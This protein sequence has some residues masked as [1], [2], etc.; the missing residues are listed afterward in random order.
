M[1]N[2]CVII[3]PT[4]KHHYSFIMLHPMCC[5]SSYFND[6]I[7]YFNNNFYNNRKNRNNRNNRNNTKVD[8]IKY[9]LPESPII[10]VDYPNNKQYNIKSWYNYYTCYN[11]LNKIDIIDVNQYNIESNNI[12]NIINNEALILG[13]FKKIFLLGVSQGGTLLFNILNLCSKPLGGIFCIKSLYMY[14][15][16]NLNNNYKT[17]LYFYSGNKDEIYNLQLQKKSINILKKN[18]KVYW[19]IIKNLDHHTKI[20]EEFKFVWHYFFYSF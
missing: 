5:D 10:D 2:N 6:Y 19:T 11:N 17:P 18:Y 15:H 8:N 4:K 20:E 13:D 1:Y 12:V 3:N 9:I 16:T 7:N 14:T